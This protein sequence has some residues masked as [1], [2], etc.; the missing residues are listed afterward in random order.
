M[1]EGREYAGV[2]FGQGREYYQQRRS[3]KDEA[4]WKGLTCSRDAKQ[5]D[6]RSVI[7]SVL[8]VDGNGSGL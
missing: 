3:D 7:A 5:V 1:G 2:V 8:A 4:S 6:G